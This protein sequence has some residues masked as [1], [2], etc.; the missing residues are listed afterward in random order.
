MN[1]EDMHVICFSVPAVVRHFYPIRPSTSSCAPDTL[2]R[3]TYIGRTTFRIPET[4]NHL[5]LLFILHHW[6]WPNCVRYCLRALEY[7]SSAAAQYSVPV[8]GGR[9]YDD[10]LPHRR[11][12]SWLSVHHN[13]WVD[14]PLGLE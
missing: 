12:A 11:S 4:P 2:L 9:G 3:S 8:D 7:H 13:D 5:G 1:E 14:P 6:V 10:L